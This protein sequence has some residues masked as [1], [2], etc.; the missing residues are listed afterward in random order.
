GITVS[1]VAAPVISS[2]TY[3]AS[4]GVLVVTGTNIPASGSS[5][6]DAS[7]LTFT[8]EGSTTYTLT[9][10]S[11]VNRDATTQFTVTLSVTDKSAVGQILNKN[12]DT[13]SGN[14]T[15]NL[16]AAEDW[17]TGT[18]PSEDIADATNAIIVSNVPVPT[19]TSATFD[20][21]TGALVVT[22][23]G[24][25][26][27]ASP[28]NDIDVSK[29]TFTGE[30]G[31]TYTIT[32]AT[33]VEI[34]SGTT[35]TVTLSGED[36]LNIKGLLNKDDTSSDDVT[37]YNLA[38]AE[39]WATG[40]DAAVNVVDAAGNGITVSNV[41]APVISSATYDASTGVLVVTGTNL[42]RKSGVSN[43]IDVIFLT[44][45]GEASGTYT[46]TSS[47]VEITSAT[48]FSVIL[49]ST[50]KLNVS[51]LLN[52]NGTASG[53]DTTYNLSAAEDWA[54]GAAASATIADLTGNGITVSNVAAPVISSAT[55][56]ASTGVLVVTGTNIP[57][58]GSSDI[59]AS[60]LTFT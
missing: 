30:A 1:N 7:T 49:N 33:D 16:A 32:S 20:A 41:V 56:D 18:T 35:F 2:A 23:A 13:S 53:D 37:T 40:A 10:S 42:V 25:V 39:D 43:D 46:L 9:N 55:Y 11:D 36:L 4:T 5:D 14:T 57:A 17:A 21:S 60:T 8:G 31:N 19:I 48:A 22:G 29:F 38:A 24:F 26:K 28:T 50:D 45:K 6:I 54:A 59:D 3:D 15:Y 27:K 51:G 34:T 44:L 47:N 52:K 12:G 58:S